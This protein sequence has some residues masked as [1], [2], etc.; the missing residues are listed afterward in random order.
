MNN[1]FLN[2]SVTVEKRN[3]GII[4]FGSGLKLGPVADNTIEWLDYWAAEEPGRIF[5]AERDGDGWR[6]VTYSQMREMV[7][8]TAASL[9]TRGVGPGKTVAVISGP[10]VDHGILVLATQLIG[11]V[12]VPL[13]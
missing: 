12:L 10:S 5:L 11:A 9:L 7:R 1:T 3:D 13:A 4:I 8:N 6:E 2:H